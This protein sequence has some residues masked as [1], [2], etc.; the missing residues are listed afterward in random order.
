MKKISAILFFAIFAMVFFGCEE[1]GVTP[2]Q[3]PAP[4]VYDN[5]IMI[6]AFNATLSNGTMVY[7][8]WKTSIVLEG[9]ISNPPIQIV[10]WRWEFGDGGYAT[11]QRVVYKPGINPGDTMNV[12]LVATDDAGATHEAYITIKSTWNIMGDNLVVLLSS[13]SNGNGTYTHRILFAIERG[14][15][16]SRFIRGTFTNWV[17][18][19]LS[20][21]LYSYNNG[22][23]V[24]DTLGFYVKAN[25]VATAGNHLFGIMRMNGSNEIWDD[26]SGSPYADAN[27]GTNLKFY[28]GEGGTITP[29]GAPTVS[30]PGDF[31]DNTSEWVTSMKSSNSGYIIF[32]N[33]M[34]PF[35]SI[36]PFVSF[37]NS[38]GG[39]GPAIAETAVSGF[40]NAGQVTKT[41]TPGVM[42]A[43]RLGPDISQPNVF[44]IPLMKKCGLW[45][46]E[47]GDIRFVPIVLVGNKCLV[48]Q[49]KKGVDFN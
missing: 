39:Y 20:D 30:V 31:G 38:S 35:S 1:I 17:R 12:R 18:T 6:K 33:N 29:G 45:N 8:P 42:V 32:I 41:I 13:I 2:T 48:R 23:Y 25:I 21:T 11:G 10:N 14:E 9:A 49:A 3:T 26:F 19:P 16:G 34:V 28:Q 40:P 4:R 7:V 5:A 43:L 24:P 36:S 44:N 47:Y 37:R 46:E 15:P 27:N 22:V